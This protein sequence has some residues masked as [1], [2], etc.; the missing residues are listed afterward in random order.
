MDSNRGIGRG[1]N[2]SNSNRGIERG[3]NGSN[4][5][6]NDR[7]RNSR[8]RSPRRAVLPSANQ[9]RP[10]LDVQH[11]ELQVQIQDLVAASTEQREG[12]RIAREMLSNENAR[13]TSALEA[14]STENQRLTSALTAAST[15]REGADSALKAAST[16]NERLT[17]ALDAASSQ[18]DDAKSK[19]SEA[20]SKLHQA[21]LDIVAKTSAIELEA[22]RSISSL[23]SEKT[24]LEAE[25]T[26]LRQKLSIAETEA[27]VANQAAANAVQVVANTVAGTAQNALQG[28]VQVSMAHIQATGQENQRMHDT[29]RAL[30]QYTA[31]GQASEERTAV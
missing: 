19:L 13:L 15:Q 16:K 31:Q 3:G 26:T 17:S 8:S 5:G 11:A 2:G 24:V 27:R 1:G 23:Q 22:T 14:A 25:V 9:R 28:Q 30:M 6:R 12:A 7:P 4:R 18:R 21:E 10:T 20:Q 29:S